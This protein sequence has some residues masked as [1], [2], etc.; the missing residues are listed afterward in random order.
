MG[1]CRLVNIKY[2]GPFMENV[3]RS[4]TST[5]GWRLTSLELIEVLPPGLCCTG[6]DLCTALMMTETTAGSS[7]PGRGQGYPCST[8]GGWRFAFG[9]RTT[10]VIC[11]FKEVLAKYGVDLAVWAHEHSYERL[12]P[13]MNRQGSK[14]F[15]KIEYLWIE[16]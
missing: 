5:T 12:L 10:R 9:K 3:I 16:K 11:D 8:C 2:K 1:T 13:V 4:R 6:T 14:L 15:R 7:R